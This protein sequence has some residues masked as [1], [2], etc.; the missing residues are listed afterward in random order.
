MGISK[1]EVSSPGIS[2]HVMSP[3]LLSVK[4]YMV[5]S[6]EEDARDGGRE[7]FHPQIEGSWLI[8][9]FISS[10]CALDLT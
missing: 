9:P 3:S 8:N 1:V 6:G 4:G 2:I 7:E 10:S 5:A